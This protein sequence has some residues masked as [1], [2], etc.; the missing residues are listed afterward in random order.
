MEQMTQRRVDAAAAPPVATTGVASVF[1]MAG[2]SASAHEVLPE[3]PQKGQ[4]TGQRAVNRK[5]QAIAALYQANGGRLNRTGMA[6]ALGIPQKQAAKLLSNMKQ[7]KCVVIAGEI[8][9][10][11]AYMVAP[12][13]STEGRPKAPKGGVRAGGSEGTVPAVVAPAEDADE[14]VCGIFNNGQLVIQVPGQPEYH[15]KKRQVSTLLRFLTS[16]AKV[17][18]AA[19]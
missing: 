12:A 11:T 4:R 18:A 9:G 10:L 2:S 3:V 1:A 13:Q 17:E 19:Q 14:L 8:D 15:L 16:M 7:A 5:D 6:E